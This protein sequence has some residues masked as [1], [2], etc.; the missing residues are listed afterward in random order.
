MSERYLL[1]IPADG[2]RLLVKGWLWLGLAALLGSGLFSLL[3]VL[4]RMPPL[5]T[6]FPGIDFFRTALVV[7]VDLSVLVWF[8][9]CAGTLWSINTSARRI[10]LG[11]AALGFAGAGAVLMALAPFIG[12]GSP[13]L[14]NYVPVLR[15]PIFFAGLLSFAFGIA[16]L[17][18][19]SM[20]A[21]PKVGPAISGAAALRFGLNT[22]AVSVA[23]ALIA[24]A[25][26]YVLI[27]DFIKD[28]AYYELLFWGGGH[29]LSFSYT[30][31]MLLAWLWLA[32]TSGVGLALSPRV[33]LIFFALGLAA[34]F[35]M[36]IIYA[37]FDI[38]SQEHKT[39]FTGLMRYGGSI[40]T[41]P[42]A[43]AIVHG[44]LRSDPP[45]PPQAPLRTALLASILL[46]GT[47]GI[48]GFLI[49]GSNVTIPAHY[50]GAFVGIT[51]ALMGLTYD[52][53]PRLGY[54]RPAQ[55]LARVQLRLY[56]TGQ[57]LHV[58]GL[59]W[60]GGYGVQRKIAGTAQALDRLQEIASMGLMGL[61]GLIAVVGGL[62]FLLV[63][64]RAFAGSSTQA[65]ETAVP[66]RRPA[67]ACAS[68]D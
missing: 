49:N 46:F 24:F 20:T 5:H 33:A 68:C 37:V 48:T 57:F 14:S 21:M 59:M 23:L 19:H 60:S 56:A 38:T 39:V 64:L 18:C 4:S 22:M 53:L 10:A 30:L 26:S 40:A 50:H 67:T 27:P 66:A 16:I 55:G 28:E 35:V 29:M 3:L 34:V 52:L 63:V 51:L 7:H 36:P 65:A 41:L 32:T 31:L 2:R 45:S 25:W 6:V 1:A 62:L 17:V 54:A 9:A 11:W 12:G 47:G 15:E 43:L 44:L 61:G 58:L 13:L 8:L 42:L